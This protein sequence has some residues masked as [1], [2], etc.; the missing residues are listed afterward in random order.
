[1]DNEVVGSDGKA[2]H[3]PQLLPARYNTQTE[4]RKE[5]KPGEKN[6]IDFELKSDTR[7]HE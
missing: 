6:E 4:L 3:R 5:V 1:M 7:K 2:I